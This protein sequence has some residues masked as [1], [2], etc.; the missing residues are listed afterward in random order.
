[1]EGMV[2]LYILQVLEESSVVDGDVNIVTYHG[3]KKRARELGIAYRAVGR[4]GGSWR[5]D[6]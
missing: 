4:S 6:H 2:V 1:V 5:Y 3:F